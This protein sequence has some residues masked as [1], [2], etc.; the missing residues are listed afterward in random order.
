[1]KKIVVSEVVGRKISSRTD[2]KLFRQKLLEMMKKEKRIVLDF[3]G[4]EIAS[5]SFLDEAFGR[6][7]DE[8][9]LEELKD[10]L[11]FENMDDGDRKLLNFVILSRYKEKEKLASL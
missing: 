11:A 10:R 8:F 6:L 7:T 5:V 9:S 4:L 3:T 2:G 1:M